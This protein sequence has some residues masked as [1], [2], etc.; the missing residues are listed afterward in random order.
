MREHISSDE[1]TIYEVYKRT[2]KIAQGAKPHNSPQILKEDIDKAKEEKDHWKEKALSGYKNA[3]ALAALSYA[4]G[5]LRD[6]KY[7]TVGRKFLRVMAL[8]GA[9]AAASGRGYL[10]GLAQSSADQ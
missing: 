9:N 4:H 2:S 6:A 8:T 3:G 7:A 1:T 10:L 5:A